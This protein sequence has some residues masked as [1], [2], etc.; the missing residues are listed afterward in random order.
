MSDFAVEVT[1][2]NARLWV[3]IRENF[4]SQADF[5]RAASMSQSD[6]SALLRMRKRPIKE[7]G[8]WTDAA[9]RI[10]A[11][12]QRDPDAIW[13]SHLRDGVIQNNRAEF[14]VALE[15]V[16]AVASDGDPFRVLAMRQMLTKW[17]AAVTSPLNLEVLERRIAGETLEE[18]GKDIGFS[19]ERV[20]QREHMALLQIRNAAARDGVKSLNDAQ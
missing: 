12:L 2:R 15:D 7:D 5:A 19:R 14:T 4:S 10:A 16:Q 1:V 9:Y 18:I 17:K 20:R 8:E 13:P 3:L 11:A 6:L